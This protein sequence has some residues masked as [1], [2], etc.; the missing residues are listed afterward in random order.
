MK[1]LIDIDDAILTRAMELSE[2]PTKKAVV[3]HALRDYVR[4]AEAELYIRH[5]ENGM[6]VDLD[7]P[8]VIAEAQR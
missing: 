5:L 6:S 8:A 2:A 3:N 4:R 1:T 7:D